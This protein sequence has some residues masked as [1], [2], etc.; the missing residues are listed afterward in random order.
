MGEFL[1]SILNRIQARASTTLFAVYGSFWLMLHA[2]G[3]V[4]LL[5]TDQSY[6]YQKFGM[7][8]NEYLFEYFFGIAKHP[9]EFLIKQLIAIALTFLY[10]RYFARFVLNPAYRIEIKYKYNRKIMKAKQERKLRLQETKLM[11]AK[12]KQTEE[13][14]KLKEVEKEIEG[15]NPE[16]K[17]AKEYAKLVANKQESVIDQLERL[18]YDYDG[19]LIGEYDIPHIERDAL[20]VCESLQLV[21]RNS[22][23]HNYV[24]ITQKG[25]YFIKRHRNLE[26]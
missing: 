25:W 16:A 24:I 1:S 12:I 14:Q 5:F 23:N 17:W 26:E 20:V 11:H 2:E 13:K 4:A 7:L 10:V 8:K 15:I 9:I 3:V 22:R 18:Y 21:E 19:K 6:I